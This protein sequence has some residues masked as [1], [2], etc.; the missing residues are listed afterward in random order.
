[1]QKSKKSNDERNFLNRLFSFEDVDGYPK[2]G[3]IF[4]LALGL[5]LGL[6]G[7]AQLDRY[8]KQRAADVRA[9]EEFS[10]FKDMQKYMQ[11]SWEMEVS[12]FRVLGTDERYNL[13]QNERIIGDLLVGM[14]K[15]YLGSREDIAR[16][17]AQITTTDNHTGS[18]L[19]LTNFGHF[20][21]AYHV[22]EGSNLQEINVKYTGK[23][24]VGKVLTYSR[25]HDVAF[26]ILDKKIDKKGRVTCIM[27]NLPQGS[28]EVKL[29][30]GITQTSPQRGEPIELYGVQDGRFYFQKGLVTDSDVTTNGKGTNFHLVCT[31]AT[32]GPGYSGGP[33]FTEGGA[34]VGITVTGNRALTKDTYADLCA[35]RV[36]NLRKLLEN[37]KKQIE[38][39]K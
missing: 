31:N 19:I 28:L 22:I 18:G 7:Y 33:I 37:Y 8:I 25:E 2:V 36:D 13:W 15:R 39:E 21:T 5:A 12:S 9:Q 11:K 30:V 4:L 27:P 16:N 23:Q 10:R 32:V 26:G 17:F 14:N 38:L 34:L 20:V 35:S 24:Y 1:M 29:N 6:R 3:K